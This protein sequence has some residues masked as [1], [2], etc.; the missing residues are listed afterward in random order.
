[1]GV[2][3]VINSDNKRWSFSGANKKFKCHINQNKFDSIKLIDD[4]YIVGDYL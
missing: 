4:I 1:M 2:F 3:M